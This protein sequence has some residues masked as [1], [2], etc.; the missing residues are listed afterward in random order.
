MFGKADLPGNGWVHILANRIWQKLEPYKSISIIPSC[1]AP[2][3]KIAPNEKQAVRTTYPVSRQRQALSWLKRTNP[4][5]LNSSR[6]RSLT[7][8]RSHSN[9]HSSGTSQAS[10]F[11]NSNGTSAGQG[12]AFHSLK[13][14]QGERCSWTQTLYS[15]I[16]SRAKSKA[17]TRQ[18]S[19]RTSASPSGGDLKRLLYRGRV[20]M[21][22]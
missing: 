6:A 9:W 8:F 4:S 21:P 15:F 7:C 13:R 16:K 20:S 10:S 12:R 18:R 2:G 22:A 11:Q 14:W 17:H 1:W 19:T 3:L 5:L